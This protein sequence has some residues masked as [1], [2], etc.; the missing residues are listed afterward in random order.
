MP[1]KSIDWMLQLVLVAALSNPACSESGGHA[2][3]IAGTGAIQSA[4]RDA[5]ASGSTGGA[6][7]ARR[8]ASP[9]GGTGGATSARR[10][11][12][13]SGTGGAMPEHAPGRMQGTGGVGTVTATD[14]TVYKFTLTV[15]G[16]QI[17]GPLDV[18]VGG[19]AIKATL[20]VKRVK[21]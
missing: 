10:D 9:S 14:G 4:P 5:G 17:K 6:T 15:D 7:S 16:D 2:G 18:S 3:A 12:G 20:D 13:A 11:A 8:D 21:G 19:Q 1:T